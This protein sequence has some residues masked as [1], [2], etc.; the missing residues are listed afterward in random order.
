MG[1]FEYFPYTNFHTLN[2][3]ELIRKM[4]EL[5]AKV[6]ELEDRVAELEGG[7]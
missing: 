6:K 3:D 4:M 7:E 2:L 1:A 5:E